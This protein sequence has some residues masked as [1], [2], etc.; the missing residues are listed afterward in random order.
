MLT[1]HQLEQR[2]GKVTASLVPA[3]CGLDP[4]KGPVQAFLEI[5]GRKLDEDEAPIAAE[6]GSLLEEPI[7]R[8]TEQK[9]GR[10]IRRRNIWRVLQD[11]P[12]AG[13]VG[14]TLD[15]DYDDETRYGE[16]KTSG[17]VHGFGDH[18]AWGE[19]GTDEV[20][21]RVLVQVATQML[22]S[23]E[24]VECIVP[25]LIGRNKGLAIY[26]VRRDADLVGVVGERIAKFFRDYIETDTMP[27]LESGVDADYVIDV[28]RSMGSKVGASV[29]IDPALAA[30]Y[31]AARDMEKAGEEA[32][33]IA[34]AKIRLVLDGAEVGI[35]DGWSISHKRP[36]DSLV[37]D[38][39]A[40][41]ADN[42]EL[43]ARYC[44]LRPS[45]P[46]LLVTAKK[47]T[48]KS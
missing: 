34:G 1:P 21:E 35:A 4:Y 6:I 45:S 39:A 3:I 46:R 24:K 36:K 18:S 42:P 5:T 40:F 30:E 7:I 14:A 44:S 8:L 22:V 47:A 28:A 16:V 17:L 48:V 19:E 2:K 10:K 13:K 23:P 38:K 31:A 29:E 37:F 33:K 43:F 27:P 12:L 11:G 9:T 25:A 41:V 26:R 32:K 15:F 20:P